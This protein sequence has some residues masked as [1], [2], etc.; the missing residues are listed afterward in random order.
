MKQFEANYCRTKHQTSLEIT[1]VIS[2]ISTKMNELDELLLSVDL[3]S[4][5]AKVCVSYS[6]RVSLLIGKPSNI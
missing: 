4:P 3:P 1:F 5:R 2:N 6:E